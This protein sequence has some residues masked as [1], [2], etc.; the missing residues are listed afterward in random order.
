MTHQTT[1]PMEVL[2]RITKEEVWETK[3][4]PDSGILHLYP[5][6]IPDRKRKCS[7]SVQWFPKSNRLMSGASLHYSTNPSELQMHRASMVINM[8]YWPCNCYWNQQKQ[9]MSLKYGFDV[10]NGYISDEDAHK[11]LTLPYMSL[12]GTIELFDEYAKADCKNIDILDALS[13][14][15]SM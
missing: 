11:V 4:E 1:T 2:L 9:T 10:L 5:I 3:Y 12:T 14:D 7:A 6:F 8:D 15:V 13:T